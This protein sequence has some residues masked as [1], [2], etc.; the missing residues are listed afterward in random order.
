MSRDTPNVLLVI[1]DSARARNTSLH[2][3][4]RRTTPFLDEFAASATKYTQ[5]RSAAGW[6]LPSHASIFTG[7]LPQEHGVNGLDTKLNHGASI[8]E[9]LANEGYA[10]GLFTD[11]PYLTDLDTGLS[12]GFDVVVNDKDLFQDGI[13]PAAFTEEEN[14]DRVAFLRAALNSDA[15]LKSVLN[16]AAWMLKWHSPWFAEGTVFTRGFTYAEHFEEWREGIDDPWAAC[17]NLMDTH[18]PFR[19]AEEY[20]QWATDD[21]RAARKSTNEDD[22][23]EGEEWKHALRQNRY[24][25]TIQQADAVVER[26]VDGL[27]SAGELDDTLVVVTADHGEGFGESDPITDAPVTG[28]NDGTTEPLLHVPLI[29]QAPG[30]HDNRVVDDPVGLV[31]FPKVVRETVAGDDPSF[32]TGRMVFAGGLNDGAIVDVAYDRNESAGVSKYVRIDDDVWTVHAAT[33]FV[34]YL[35]KEGAPADVVERMASLSEADVTAES[36]GAVTEI[37]RQQLEALGYKE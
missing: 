28:H 26:I 23:K 35:V 36:E 10:T 19:P 16:G 32:E 37:A 11:N 6:S 33:P 27:R 4:H 1:L 34:N 20:D 9:W 3:Y 14:T 22:V 7:S 15:P 12:N 24:D 21:T 30:Q 17:L 2:G 29:V 25:G 18:I 8:F 5:A 31:D 13:S